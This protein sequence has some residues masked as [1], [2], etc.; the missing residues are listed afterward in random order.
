MSTSGKVKARSRRRK[1]KVA[2]RIDRRDVENENQEKPLNVSG[3]RSPELSPK[4]AA[5]PESN[6]MPPAKRSVGQK[7][8][9][10]IPFGRNAR[11]GGLVA[12]TLSSLQQPRRIAPKKQ[13]TFV[14]ML[15]SAQERD[16]IFN[17][18]VD[19]FE[20]D[21][22]TGLLQACKVG[23]RA[24]LTTLPVSRCTFVLLI[25]F[26]VNV[27]LQALDKEKSGLLTPDDLVYVFSSLSTVTVS[28]LKVI[29]SK[30]EVPIE[31]PDLVDYVKF[32]DQS[33]CT[34]NHW[35]RLLLWFS[36]TGR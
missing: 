35:L 36:S 29:I 3:E 8:P 15:N 23:E 4:A 11:R 7:S 6:K 33:V 32:L 16:K 19:F 1:E 14:A 25:F 26:L 17:A 12:S 2:P 27:L 31:T 34:T 24:R 13:S 22:R 9:Q 30:A 5:S 18:G 28:E 20:N 21:A 10:R